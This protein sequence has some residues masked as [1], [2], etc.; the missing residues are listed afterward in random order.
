MSNNNPRPEF[1]ANLKALCHNFEKQVNEL[2]L[3]TRATLHHNRVGF[4]RFNYLIQYLDHSGKGKPGCRQMEGRSSGT[5]VGD[6]HQAGH[7]D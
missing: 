1:M 3:E 2:D 7:S 5:E 4:T 6:Q